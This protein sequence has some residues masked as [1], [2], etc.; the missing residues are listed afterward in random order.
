MKRFAAAARAKVADYRV[1]A[2]HS[3][4]HTLRVTRYTLHVTR[5]TLHVTRYTLQIGAHLQGLTRELNVVAL[6]ALDKV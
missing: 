5:Y 3:T 1:I 4:H 6:N 2:S